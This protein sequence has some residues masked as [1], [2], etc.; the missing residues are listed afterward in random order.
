MS[1]ETR[2]IAPCG[3]NCGICHAYLRE[4]NSCPGCYSVDENRWVSIARC[5]IRKCETIKLNESGFCYECEKYPCKRM[6]Q[7]DKRYSSRYGVSN[8]KNLEYIRENGLPAFNEKEKVQWSCPQCGGT[9]CVH[10]GYCL[11]CGK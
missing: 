6:K 9:I 2:L 4:K 8:L 10:K 7:L 11:T 5:I 1:D 3:L